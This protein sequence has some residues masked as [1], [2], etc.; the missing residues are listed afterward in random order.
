MIQSHF[1][2]VS[3]RLLKVSELLIVYKVKDVESIQ[4][5]QYNRINDFS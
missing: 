5:N 1:N 3:D 2:I 4:V